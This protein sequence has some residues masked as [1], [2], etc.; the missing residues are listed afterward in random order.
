MDDVTGTKIKNHAQGHTVK[1]KRLTEVDNNYGIVK[2]K[3]GW[4]SVI[5]N[6]FTKEFASDIMCNKISLSVLKLGDGLQGENKDTKFQNHGP[7]RWVV[8]PVNK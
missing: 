3:T 2:N 4:K 7:N 1:E 8:S 5:Q 6:Q